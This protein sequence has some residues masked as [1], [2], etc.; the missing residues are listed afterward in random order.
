MGKKRPYNSL[1]TLIH[2]GDISATE[3]EANKYS[4]LEKCDAVCIFSSPLNSL[5]CT[6]CTNG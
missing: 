2:F 3:T 4:N 1:F 6:Y 5:D